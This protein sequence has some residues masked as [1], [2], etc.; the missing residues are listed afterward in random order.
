M[1][2]TMLRA[3]GFGTTSRICCSRGR[4]GLPGQPICPLLQH[5]C[6]AKTCQMVTAGCRPL[7]QDAA[8]LAASRSQAS[9]PRP[10]APGRH[11][12]TP[13]RRRAGRAAA[14]P[15]CASGGRPRTAATAAAAAAALPAAENQ[16][17]GEEL[18]LVSE[19]RPSWLNPALSQDDANVVDFLF[20]QVCGWVR[21]LGGTLARMAGSAGGHTACQDRSRGGDRASRHSSRAT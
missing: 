21:T 17:L 12:H 3:Q 8:S 1:L 15:G 11:P 16:Q 5:F 4:E 14:P 19:Q 7:Q 9:Q 2:D 18:G 10:S 20:R 13:Q 6:F